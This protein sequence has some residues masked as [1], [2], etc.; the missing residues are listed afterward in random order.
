MRPIT[1][2]VSVIL[3]L[4][5][6]SASIAEPIKELSK[7]TEDGLLHLLAHE[8]GHAV[9]REF[10]LPILGTEEDIADDFATIYV[11][12][13]LPDRAADIIGARAKQ[14]MAEDRFPGIFSEYRS[15]RQRAGRSVCVLYG[16]DPERYKALAK[17]FRLNGDDA[18]ACR[19]F[20]TEVG[21]SW[22]RIIDDYRM[23]G[24]VEVT[25]VG[26]S[27]SATLTGRV[28]EQSGFL[29]TAYRLLSGIDWHSRITLSIQECDRSAYWARNGRK[30][31]F[32]NKYIESLEAQLK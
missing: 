6:S 16:Q 28:V 1:F 22:R 30:I 26:I 25:E 24:N 8:M 7:R 3:A 14:H 18:S 12:L 11:H 20:A 4:S 5:L 31:T 19:D 15:S 13:M 21:R 2:V 9:L 29:D 17:E 10:D 32:C 23:P 27:I